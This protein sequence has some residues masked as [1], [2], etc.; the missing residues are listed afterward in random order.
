MNIEIRKAKNGEDT[1]AADNM[2]LHSSYAP[3]REAEHFVQNLTFPFIPEII[4]LI[5][6]ALSYSAKIIKEKFSSIDICFSFKRQ[7]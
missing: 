1:A 4:I 3:S 7:R 2:L 6:P 5:E